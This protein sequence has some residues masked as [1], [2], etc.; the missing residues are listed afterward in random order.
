MVH[1]ECIIRFK[2]LKINKQKTKTKQKKN[3]NKHKKTKT[4]KT[5]QTWGLIL[6]LKELM[7][8]K[9]VWNIILCTPFWNVSK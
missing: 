1:G 5:K 2:V 8:K 4:K 6:T 9:I 7:K 3:E